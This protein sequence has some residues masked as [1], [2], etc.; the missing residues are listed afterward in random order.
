MRERWK[1]FLRLQIFKIGMTRISIMKRKARLLIAD[2]HL[3][4]ADGYKHLLEPEF[5]IVGIVTDRRMLLDSLQE[6]EPDGVI[7]ELFLPHLNGL[8]AA[9]LIKSSSSSPKLIFVTASSDPQDVAEAFRRGASAYV[10]Q[11]S[12]A[13]EFKMAIRS[14]MDGR[15][16]LC[17]LIARETV[18]YLLY[19]WPQGR[20][21]KVLRP[22]QSE[23]LQLL[24]EGN[25]MKRVADIL[26]I[27][28]GAVAF[29]KYSMMKE[30]R[31]DSNAELLQYAMKNHMIPSQSRWAATSISDETEIEMFN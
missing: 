25:S 4:M 15:S 8:D 26:A 2:N 14:A 31:I 24:V 5:E 9:D 27:S 12:G 17:N 22:R 18:D 30:L 13:E 10:L 23:I 7:L 1:S 21:E 6:F 19:Q 28:P 3:I 16:Y 11:Q 29:H 20:Q